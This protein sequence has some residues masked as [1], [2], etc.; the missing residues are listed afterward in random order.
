MSIHLAFLKL[1]AIASMGTPWGC[2]NLGLYIILAYY[3]YVYI[4]IY[5]CMWLVV[6]EGGGRG[7]GLNL[8]SLY[9][10]RHRYALLPICTD[11]CTMFVCICI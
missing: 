6:R 5:F 10:Y 8:L 11:L 9:S 3:N 1:R 4:Y 2:R 7:R